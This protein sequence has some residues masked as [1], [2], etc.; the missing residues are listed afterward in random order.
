MRFNYQTKIHVN[1]QF[2][3]VEKTINR[4]KFLLNK[5][6]KESNGSSVDSKNRL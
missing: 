6:E 5:A 4:Y 1:L 3:I 2:T